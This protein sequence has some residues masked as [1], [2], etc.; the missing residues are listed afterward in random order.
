MADEKVADP[1]SLQGID[2]LLH[3]MVTD[4]RAGPFHEAE[5]HYRPILVADP[6]N[7]ETWHLLGL[8]AHQAGYP[9]MGVA[10]LRQALRLCPENV[11]YLNSLGSIYLE[12]GN[13]EQ[14]VPCFE[15][16]IRLDP[17]QLLAYNSLGTALTQLGRYEEAI[18]TL[19]TSLAQD[20]SQLTLH[21]K[22]GEINQQ[23]GRFREAMTGYRLA[24][25]AV[26]PFGLAHNNYLN[27]TNHLH[28]W[29]AETI[30]DEHRFWGVRAALRQPCRYSNALDPERPLRIGY[31]SADF[32][33]H[34]VAR[35]IEPILRNHNRVACLIFL[36]AEVSAPDELTQRLQGLGHNWRITN[37][38][39]PED[40]ARQVR[41]DAI[42]ILVDLTG[43]NPSNRLDVFAQQPAPIQAT[44]LGY[45]NTTG[46]PA[47]DCWL[48]DKVLHPPD[49]P[50]LAVERM[51]H[52]PEAFFCFEPPASAPPVS[53]LPALRLG[54]FTFGS[55]QTFQNLNDDVLALWSR[56]LQ[57]VPESRLLFIDRSRSPRV[58]DWL[59]SRFQPLGIAPERIEVRQP[60]TD[61]VQ[62]LTVYGE[63]DLI[64]DA[65]PF[66]GH[67]STCEALWMGVPVVTLRGERTASRLSAAV[68]TP[69]GL[70]DLIAATPEEYLER[71]QRLAND[72]AAL[73][74][75]RQSLRERMGRLCDGPTFTH[76]LEATYRQIWRDWCAAQLDATKAVSDSRLPAMVRLESP[77]KTAHSPGQ[78][79]PNREAFDSP[80]PGQLKSS[81][82]FARETTTAFLWPT[83]QA[84]SALACANAQMGTFPAY[85]GTLTYTAGLIS[86]YSSTTTSTSATGSRS[87]CRY[88]TCCNITRSS[89]WP[90]PG[91]SHR[92]GS[93]GGD[94]PPIPV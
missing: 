6:S 77:R 65:F 21:N 30:F 79:G 43:H 70:T 38:Q 53:P 68:L 28:D 39:T 45:P 19:Q 56:I 94:R 74:A 69:L 80:D 8:I 37:G 44:Y 9:L 10:H 57:A 84:E 73:T 72:P 12:N 48:T 50:A 34:S 1:A 46:L 93:P 75:L 25:L 4:H 91:P 83:P 11:T 54:R 89:V 90:A 32:R 78:T 18:Q 5:L 92:N 47:M 22:L 82:R 76:Q 81:C 42:D 87:S 62:D 23:L 86:S 29:D 71:A 60:D 40:V 58:A 13:D 66:T 31:V 14:A 36:Y 64:L 15:E 35:F 49:E 51:V 61:D 85:T 59:R 17:L 16:V 7:A 88:G 3:E 41:E 52:L 63:I 2:A 33:A 55:H 20:P 24:S 26:P 27:L 67:T